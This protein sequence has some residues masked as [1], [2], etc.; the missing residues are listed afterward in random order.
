M[1]IPNHC[2]RN[3]L[4]YNDGKR[5]ALEQSRLA[6][7]G[8]RFLQRFREDLEVNFDL[9]L[10]VLKNHRHLL[11]G[12]GVCPLAVQVVYGMLLEYVLQWE[13]NSI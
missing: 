11:D 10:W 2:R 9:I 7:R 13:I 4:A 3:Y 6:H 8:L 5:R 12:T 1:R